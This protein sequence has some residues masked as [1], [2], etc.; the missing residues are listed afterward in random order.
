MRT[1]DYLALLDWRRRVADMYADVRA[2]LAGDAIEAHRKWRAC[3][4]DLFRH[5][6]QSALP[7]GERA[8][9][10]GLRYFAYDVAFAFAAKIRPLPEQR[11]VI[12]TGDGTMMRFVRFGAVDLPLGT[13]EVM[14]LDAYSGGVF[15]PF[16][17]ATSNITTYGGGRYL[18]DS[19]KGADLGAR[20][21]ELVLDFNFAYHP[22]CAYDS[23][24]ACPLAPPVNKLAVA[25]EAGERL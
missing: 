6:P 25:I 11:Y 3:R 4:D 13:L 23:T 24:W 15:L 17:D 22:S 12:P 9:F 1:A 19:A 21:E 18:L 16:A 7:S 14:W 20:G 8:R 10:E 5:H 2:R